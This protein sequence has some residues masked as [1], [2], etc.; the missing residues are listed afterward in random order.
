MSRDVQKE[1]HGDRSK[2]KEE[3]LMEASL[4]LYTISNSDCGC[5]L[6]ADEQGGISTCADRS[7]IFTSREQD[8]LAHIL[9][10]SDRARNLKHELQRLKT[11]PGERDDL[12]WVLA[13]LAGL[14]RERA[15][16]EEERLAAAEERMRELGHV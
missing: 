14:R 16:L 13:E 6:T 7:K 8:V 4:E 3:G 11:H 9:A 5:C 1:R 2:S 10:A 12:A 15:A